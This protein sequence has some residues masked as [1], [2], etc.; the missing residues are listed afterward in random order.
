MAALGRGIMWGQGVGLLMSTPPDGYMPPSTPGRPRG[1][2]GG[3]RWQP[4][5][6]GQ[7]PPTGQAAPGPTCTLLVHMFW[8]CGRCCLW[9]L[10]LGGPA[11]AGARFSLR[12]RV[13]GGGQT[14]GGSLYICCQGICCCWCRG[15]FRCWHWHLHAIVND[16]STRCQADLAPGVTQRV[17]RTAV[18]HIL[19]GLTGQ[20][21]CW[22]RQ[23]TAQG[24]VCAYAVYCT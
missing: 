15:G 21:F 9:W 16:A 17:R 12:G 22:F 2:G 19:A 10:L 23:R 5:C 8:L 11:V 24:S 14:T 7:L 4:V 6:P 13:A 1:G 20:R 3:G 18:V